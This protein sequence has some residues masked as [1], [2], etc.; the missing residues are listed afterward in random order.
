MNYAN[1]VYSLETKVVTGG[2]ILTESQVI[3]LESKKKM[4]LPAVTLKRLILAILTPKIP[5]M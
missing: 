1:S 5:F 2:I 3:A 4:I